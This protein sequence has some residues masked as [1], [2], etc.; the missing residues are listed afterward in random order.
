MS[1]TVTALTDLTVDTSIMAAT[2]ALGTK[3][4]IEAPDRGIVRGIMLSDLD[5][6]TFTA[7]VWFFTEEP[8]GIA[9]N[10]VFDL[11]NIDQERTQ[12]VVLLPAAFDATSG[13]VRYART[14][15]PYETHGGVLWLQCALASGTPTFGVV[16]DVKIRLYIEG[17]A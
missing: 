16:T 7:N 5:D 9:T 12:G 2:D 14:D 3:V 13:K 15:L 10:A 11:A 8:T 1:I 4:G 6:D 17:Y